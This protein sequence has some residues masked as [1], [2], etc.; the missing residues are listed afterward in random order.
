M[1][2]V[3][4]CGEDLLH[5]VD[6]PPTRLGGRRCGRAKGGAPGPDVLA[7]WHGRSQALAGQMVHGRNERVRRGCGGGDVA[8]DRT[9][10]PPNSVHN[11]WGGKAPARI[12]TVERGLAADGEG[13]ICHHS[14]VGTGCGN[15]VVFDAVNR[16]VDE[17]VVNGGGAGHHPYIALHSGV[18]WEGDSH[19]RCALID[20]VQAALNDRQGCSDVVSS[21]E[22]AV[23]G[24][25]PLH[26]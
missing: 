1:P 12:L 7:I 5:A 16:A 13:D 20:Q 6:A 11:C 9:G 2:A 15:H 25:T 23:H 3:T 17:H 19:W 18:P 10:E 22:E 21:A 14:Q 4:G 26:V 8:P 24:G